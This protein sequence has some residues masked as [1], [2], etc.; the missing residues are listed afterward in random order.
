MNKI[1]IDPR[2]KYNYATWYILGLE[3]LF[4]NKNVKFDITP[5]LCLDVVNTQQYIKGMPLLAQI[6]GG[7][8]KI[9]I[10]YHDDATIASD[11]YEWCDLYAKV[12]LREEDIATHKKLLA[13]GPSFGVRD[14]N[15]FLLL[16]RGFCNYLKSK[17]HTSISFKR[18]MLDYFYPYWRRIWLSE[19]EN[20]NQVNLNYVFMLSTLWNGVNEKKHLNDIRMQFLRQCRASGINFEG[21]FYYIGSKNNDYKKYQEEYKNFLYYKRLSIS[22]YLDN[23]KKSFV[24]FNCPAV[25]GCLGWKLCEYLMLGKAI[26]SMPINHP[27]PGGGLK[28]GIHIHIVNTTDEIADALM[29]IKNDNEYRQKLEKNAKAYFD[30]YLSPKI[31][32]NR[33]IDK[34]IGIV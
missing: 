18:M 10:D 25:A 3:Q 12:N 6:G 4:G 16:W 27:M 32:V 28:H 30:E 17:K 21:G 31:V 5:F 33:I 7:I 13:I 22:E 15:V 20:K 19:Y 11:R 1:T 8:Y 29:L 34:S 26:I 23:V 24:V 2:I 14:R 9:F